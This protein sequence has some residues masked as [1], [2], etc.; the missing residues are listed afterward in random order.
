MTERYYSQHQITADAVRIEGDEARHLSRVMRAKPGD[1][2]LVF[3]G[4]GGEFVCEVSDVKRNAVDLIVRERREV[5][6]EL[7]FELTV[8]VSLPKG[9]RQRWLVEKLTELGTTRL[10]PLRTDYSVAQPSDKALERLRRAVIEASKQCGR[11]LL[12]EV[13]PAEDWR[14]FVERHAR[15]PAGLTCIVADP[16]GD[17]HVGDALGNIQTKGQGYSVAI[18]PE[19]GFSPSEIAQARE[20]NRQVVSLGAR[21]L[22][23]E[24][25]AVAVAGAIAFQCGGD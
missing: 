7:P 24:T 1:E 16:S 14:E 9:D 11:N 8:A 19:G 23:V 20:A 4:S 2:V 21:I 25:A 5:S 13:A 3:D 10:L 6:C 17:V 15:D 18:G 22:R 12:M